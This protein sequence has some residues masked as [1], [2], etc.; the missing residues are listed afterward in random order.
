M[1]C[2]QQGCHPEQAALCRRWLVLN[3]DVQRPRLRQMTEVRKFKCH[4]RFCGGLL[5]STPRLVE[6][7]ERE[8]YSARIKEED[9][10][11][12]ILQGK[13]RILMTRMLG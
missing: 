10:W 3:R 8:L 5:S 12:F 7:V 6:A 2:W 4:V 13:Q 11:F 9:V 1:P